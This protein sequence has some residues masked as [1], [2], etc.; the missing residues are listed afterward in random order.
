[1]IG[2]YWRAHP[3][4]A[5]AIEG[6]VWWMPELGAKPQSLVQSALDL[7]VSRN[8]AQKKLRADGSVIYSAKRP[9]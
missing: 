6:V 2:A 8:I 4:A 3:N 9:G 7:L 5:D 1:M